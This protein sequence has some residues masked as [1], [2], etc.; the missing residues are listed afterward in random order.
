MSIYRNELRPWE[1]P[2]KFR[3]NHVPVVGFSEPPYR[4]HA[5]KSETDQKRKFSEIVVNFFPQQQ[6]FQFVLLLDSSEEIPPYVKRK[7][8]QP[9]PQ[10]DSMAVKVSRMN[11]AVLQK[12]AAKLRESGFFE[13]KIAGVGVTKEALTARIQDTLTSYPEAAK[14]LD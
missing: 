9:K 13:G 10:S 3:I 4:Y 12:T 6:E 5:Q 7:F 11:F 2:Y 8:K 1:S 14:A